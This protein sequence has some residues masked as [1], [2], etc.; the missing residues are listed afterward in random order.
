MSGFGVNPILVRAAQELRGR[1][2]LLQLLTQGARA[3]G[4][5]R[6]PSD[7]RRAKDIHH[8]LYKRLGGGLAQL[9]V[10][11]IVGGEF[12]MEAFKCG[13]VKEALSL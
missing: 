12:E 9:G 3:S 2:G 7:A 6:A 1:Q 13:Q 8:P 10:A 11:D 4:E 5:I